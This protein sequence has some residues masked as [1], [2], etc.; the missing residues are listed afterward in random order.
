MSE[1]ILPSILSY[2][3]YKSTSSFADYLIGEHILYKR[4]QLNE[5]ILT[6]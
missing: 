6:F 5:F 1:L 2:I 4:Q 3:V